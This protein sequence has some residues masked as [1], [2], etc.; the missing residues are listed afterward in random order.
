MIYRRHDLPPTPVARPI[1]KPAL[2]VADLAVCRAPCEHYRSHAM[3]EWC[4][5]D[6]S[7]WADGSPCQAAAVR[8]WAE[9]LFGKRARCERQAAA[10]G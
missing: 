9:R 3:Q 10:M 6:V 5:L 1:P 7:Q 2:T 8:A 4:Q